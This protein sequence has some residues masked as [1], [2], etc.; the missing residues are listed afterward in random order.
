[1][2]PKN[3]T[4]KLSSMIILVVI[5][6]FGYLYATTV[7][8]VDTLRTGCERTNVLR[9]VEYDFLVSAE[10]ARHSA[11]A[12]A[13]TSRDVAIDVQAATE[14][15]ALRSALVSAVA[16]QAKFVGSPQVDCSVAYPKPW[17]LN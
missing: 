13:T 17:P 4:I 1:M 10:Q 11:A 9:Q 15:R 5:P 8:G 2:T 14:Y 6:L 3:T 16:S 12:T 7:K